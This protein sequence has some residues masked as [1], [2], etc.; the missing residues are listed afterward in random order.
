MGLIRLIKQQDETDCGVCL[1]MI[2]NHYGTD[3]ASLY[4]LREFLGTNLEGTSAFG[5]KQ[6]VETLN[7]DCQAIQADHQ[8]WK[9]KFFFGNC[10]YYD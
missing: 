10:A 9:E 4:K 8:I 1:A 5:L 7:F 2:L 3:M 6:C